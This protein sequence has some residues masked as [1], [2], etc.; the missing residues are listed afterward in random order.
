MARVCLLL[1]VCLGAATDEVS[2]SS[3]A[4][5]PEPGE[6]V[7]L[8]LVDNSASLPPLD[9]QQR[10]RAALDKMLSFI[11]GQPHRLILFAGR[12]EIHVDEPGRYLSDGKWTDF[13]FAFDKANEIIET[14]PK[15]THFKMILITDGITDPIP[16]DWRDQDLPPGADLKKVVEERTVALLEEMDAPLYVMLVGDLVGSFFVREM[17]Q[18]ANGPVAGS[19]Y[20]QGISEFFEDDGVIL[21]RFIYHIEPEKGLVQIEPILRRIVRPV[22]FRVELYVAGA[23]MLVV[24]VLVGVGVRSFPGP[25]DQEILDLR[26]N[27]PFHVAVNRW[28]RLS[29]NVPSWSLRGLSRVDS[30]KNASATFTVQE[31]GHDF[32]PDGLDLGLIDGIPRELVMLPL[33]DLRRRMDEFLK[34]GDKVEMIEALNLDYVAPDFDSARAEKMLTSAA[35][36]RRTMDVMEFLRAKIHLLHNDDLCDKLTGPRVTCLIY[37]TN[38]AKRELRPGDRFD[39]G[40]YSYRVVELTR[41][42][43]QDYRMTLTYQGAPSALFLKRVVPGSIQQLLRFR[44]SHERVVA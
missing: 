11:E 4:R 26:L 35:A 14:Y 15:G 3:A 22:S 19:R 7:V 39:L 34:S 20:A 13:Y 6:T 27:Q 17:V 37:G 30:T 29:T 28:H 43:R 2:A 9:P 41:R 1:A 40:R 5:L 21:R 8:L 10:R 36:E 18:A 44:R 16:E 42:G 24:A 25:G 23:L 31:G 38:G 32:P 12:Q 33:P